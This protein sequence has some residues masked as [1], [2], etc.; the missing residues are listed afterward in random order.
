MFVRPVA[1]TGNFRNRTSMLF[2][3]LKKSLE[4]LPTFR[5]SLHRQKIDDLNEQQRLSATRLT[6]HLHQLLQSWYEPIIPDPQQRPTRNITYTRRLDH[7]HR[8]TSL[9][10][11]AIPIEVLLRDKPVLS[12]AP[13]HH[14]GHPCPA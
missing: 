12:R 8:R 5:S 2:T 11:P 3:D 1:F 10:K 7:Q 6:H 4:V 14:R 13:R 9:S